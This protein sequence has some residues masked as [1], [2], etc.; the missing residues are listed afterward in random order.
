MF[1]KVTSEPLAS[2]T[3]ERLREMQR[4][5]EMN[6]PPEMG[7]TEPPLLDSSSLAAIE[8]LQFKKYIRENSVM[9]AA[10]VEEY[11]NGITDNERAELISSFR[12]T[13]ASTTVIAATVPTAYGGG[14]VGGTIPKSSGISPPP[15]V[16]HVLTENAH[17]PVCP[18]CSS[19]KTTSYKQGFGVGKAAIGAIFTGGFGL[20]AG[21]IGSGKIKITCLSC[22]YSWKRG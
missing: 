7:S 21:G 14:Q 22:G 17:Q 15:A 9:S 10:E 20:L 4:I 6:I 19:V 1:A 18:K 11:L 5:K 16:I 12:S 13:L 3:I 8:K 2:L